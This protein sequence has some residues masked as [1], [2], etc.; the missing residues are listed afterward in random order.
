M[1]LL[2]LVWIVLISNIVSVKILILINRI[3][4]ILII[5]LG[6]IAFNHPSSLSYLLNISYYSSS[7]SSLLLL[8]ADIVILT[9]EIVI[10]KLNTTSKTTNTTELTYIIIR[11]IIRFKLFTWVL[12]YNLIHS[13]SFKTIISSILQIRNCLL[14]LA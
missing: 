3:L 13:L 14:V 6:S 2:L 8:L 12:L 10:I 1:L 4:L 11:R 9:W 5:Y 7:S